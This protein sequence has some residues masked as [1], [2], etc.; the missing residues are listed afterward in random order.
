[1]ADDTERHSRYDNP[2]VTRYASREMSAIFSPQSKFSTWRRLWLALA[3]AEQEVGLPITDTQIEQMRQHLDDVDF[4]AARRYEAE[5]R[6]DV[7]AHVHA[8][9]DQCPDAKP[10]IHL[11]ATSCFVT[12]NADLI[13]MRDGLE[14]L[15]ARL[16]NLMEALAIFA[17]SHRA[18]VT[19][20]Y[21][22]FQTAQPTTVGKRAC[23]WLYDFVLDYQELSRLVDA[24]PFRSIKGTTGTQA[25][26]MELFDGSHAKVRRL[27]KLV[28]AKMG[29]PCILPVCGQTY[30]RKL[31]TTILGVLVGIAQSVAKM[32]NDVRLLQHMQEVEEPFRKKQIGSSAMPHKRNPMRCE[33][34]GSLARHLICAAQSAPFTAATQWLERTLDD[35]A[36]RRVAIP[37]CFLTADA[38]LLIADNVAS[39]LVVHPKVIAKN[40]ARELPFLATERILMAAVKAGGDRQALHET[41]R[42]HV[43]DVRWQMTEEGADNDL[44]ERLKADE[45][46]AAIH[47][48]IDSLLDPAPLAGRAT[49]QVDEFLHAV[50]NPILEREAHLLGAES[51]LTV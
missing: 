34:I 24:L 18:L 16:V 14:L 9:G 31:D 26:F 33:R 23:L 7:M 32:A 39:G 37:E 4:E 45:A 40:L 12:D 13:L 43:A 11:G 19:L 17:A 22:H 20:G 44:V 3:E 35:S 21:T 6:H 38:V 49:V 30:T 1:M 5:L 50:V 10:I 25:S 48:Q 46:F 28:A 42:R 36:G 2:L 29:F 8:F 51:R 15:R 27:E 47:D 41:L